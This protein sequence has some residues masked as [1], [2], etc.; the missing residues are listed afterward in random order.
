MFRLPQDAIRR[1]GAKLSYLP[2]YSPDMNPLEEG[3]NQVKILI[4][5]NYI[6]WASLKGIPEL[7]MLHE[8]FYQLTPEHCYRYF[9]HA[10]YAY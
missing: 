9:R 6:I 3:F 2:P 5:S 4:K 1:T 8:A 10:E 7:A